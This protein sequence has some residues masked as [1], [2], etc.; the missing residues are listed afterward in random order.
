MGYPQ[1]GPKSVVSWVGPPRYWQPRPDHP[2]WA[3]HQRLNCSL[4][5]SFISSHRFLYSQRGSATTPANCGN[6]LSNLLAPFHKICTPMHTSRNAESFK[7]T[8]VPVG[9]SLLASRSA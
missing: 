6:E 4:S 1:P 2:C 8:F 9:P 5:L 7:I 3:A